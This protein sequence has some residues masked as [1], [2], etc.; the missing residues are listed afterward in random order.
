MTHLN[1][2]R[3]NMSTYFDEP[4]NDLDLAYVEHWAREIGVLDLWLALWDE[5]HK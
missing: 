1:H 5:F 3:E 2:P 4:P